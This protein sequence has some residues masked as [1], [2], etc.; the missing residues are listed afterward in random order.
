V[1][2]RV[3]GLDL[4]LTS[5]GIARITAPSL[6]PSST[7]WGTEEVRV[8][9]RRAHSLAPHKNLHKNQLL[10]FRSLRLRNLS[11]NI[12][13]LCADA[14]LVAVEG[15][16]FTSDVGKAHDRA[17]MWWLIVARLTANRIPVVE[18]TPQQL[19]MYALGRGGGRDSGKEHVLA[20]VIRRYPA[21][22]V[23]GNDEADALVLAA[24]AARFLGFPIEPSLPDLHLRAMGTVP[25]PDLPNRSAAHG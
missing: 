11:A 16:A 9:V 7:G 4:S 20:A 24:M 5:T 6:P 22:P 18:V 19:K 10:E 13:A 12:C 25:W 15:P 21:V 17:G 23:S 1:I 3:V 2:R 8:D 14:D